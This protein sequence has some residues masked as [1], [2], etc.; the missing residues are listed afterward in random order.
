MKESPTYTRHGFG[1]TWEGV[2]H[3]SG[4][5]MEES[6]EDGYNQHVFNTRMRLQRNKIYFFKKKI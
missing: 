6:Y 3:R 4:E 5:G 2:V 1:R